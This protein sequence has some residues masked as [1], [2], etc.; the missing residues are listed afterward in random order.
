MRHIAPIGVVALFLFASC[1]G[2]T[3]AE[4]AGIGC[5]EVPLSDKGIASVADP[6]NCPGRPEMSR[7]SGA[8]A[9]IDLYEA[10][11]GEKGE[12]VSASGKKP[13]AELTYAEA[14]QAC[15]KAGK[16]ICTKQEWELACTAGG[17]GRFPYGDKHVAGACNDGLNG[18]VHALPTGAMAKCRSVAGAPL[19]LMGNL[20]EFAQP[21]EV[22]NGRS[23]C[24]GSY[25]YSGSIST[26]EDDCY[27]YGVVDPDDSAVGFGFRCC[28]TIGEKR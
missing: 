21:T 20:C 22:D 26:P 12:A 23:P 13:W 11:R 18:L 9:C 16:R 4:D 25:F 14:E 5:K 15:S 2:G 6:G 10:S 24:R 17:K 8:E 3:G 19:D 7:V 28:L 27:V 1:N